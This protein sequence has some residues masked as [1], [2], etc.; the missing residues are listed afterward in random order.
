MV[1]ENNVNFILS[2]G[3]EEACCIKSSDLK[4]LKF[5]KAVWETASS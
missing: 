5:N 2:D 3:G 1:S 4:H